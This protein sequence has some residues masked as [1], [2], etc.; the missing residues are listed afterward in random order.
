MSDMVYE[1]SA[2]CPSS[3]PSRSSHSFHARPDDVE[4]VPLATALKS[5]A[6][7]ALR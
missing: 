1:D 5:D 3:K 7:V 6:A 2:G 4:H